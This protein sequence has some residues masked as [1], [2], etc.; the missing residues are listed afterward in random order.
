MAK[1]A[2]AK[3]TGNETLIA[4]ANVNVDTSRQ[5]KIVENHPQPKNK[6]V[7]KIADFLED[8][9]NVIQN[10]VVDGVAP[11][12]LETLP[13]YDNTYVQVKELFKP[14]R[15]QHPCTEVTQC[16][17]TYM[18][19]CGVIYKNYLLQNDEWMAGMSKSECHPKL[20]F[21]NHGV[22]DEL[23]WDL[24]EDLLLVGNGD[25]DDDE[26]LKSVCGKIAGNGK[27][28][29]IFM[30]MKIVFIIITLFL[31]NKLTFSFFSEVATAFDAAF[32][33]EWTTSSDLLTTLL[34]TVFLF[35]ELSTTKR[36][37]K[38]VTKIML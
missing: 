33:A 12:D 16:Q 27:G 6:H 28:E 14:F 25:D 38:L 7:K 10:L 17:K 8:Y 22:E 24:S 20:A 19:R 23:V 34:L 32:D 9:Q 1:L 31:L 30:I 36:K 2:K 21:P 13:F 29:F 11:T 35:L 18:V 26:N 4:A 37:R 3:V 5:Y 15:I